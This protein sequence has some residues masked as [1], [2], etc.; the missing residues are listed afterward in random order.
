MYVLLVSSINTLFWIALHFGTAYTFCKLPV[1]WFSPGK[2]FFRVSDCE[3][4]FYR[5]IALPKWKDKLPQF[6]ADFDKRHLKKELSPAYVDRF[7]YVTCRA[8][9][10][11]LAIPVLGYL[12]LFSVFF[13][14]RPKEELPLFAAIATFIGLCNL[15]F[16]MIQRYNR[17]RLLRL[18]RRMQA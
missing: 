2:R 9:M 3:M 15:P 5:R 18:R 8:E 1:R 17:Y 7:L 13:F 10:I 11:H 14:E 12:S 6:N 16:A 4:N